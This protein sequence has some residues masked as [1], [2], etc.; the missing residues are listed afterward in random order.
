MRYQRCVLTGLEGAA[1]NLRA[2]ASLAEGA[3]RSLSL[4]FQERPPSF[5]P[6]KISSKLPYIEMY[7]FA[8]HPY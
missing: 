7:R 2:V 5:P 4:G 1:D 6:G 3:A 8:A